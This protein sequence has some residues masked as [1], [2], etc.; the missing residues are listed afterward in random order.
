MRSLRFCPS[1][2]KLTMRFGSTAHAEQFILETRLTATSS[3]ISGLPSTHPMA[4]LPSKMVYGAMS[5][6][7]FLIAALMERLLKGH[8]PGTIHGQNFDFKTCM[9]VAPK[10][11]QY[12]ALC[13]L[14]L[15][16]INLMTNEAD[17]LAGN[18]SEGNFSVKLAAQNFVVPPRTP[19]KQTILAMMITPWMFNWWSGDDLDPS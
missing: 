19:W 1:T 7:T 15:S 17:G 2:W 12:P 4:L 6:S 18:R 13:H 9:S 3:Q 5:Q 16:M 11:C 10:R 14:T 8:D